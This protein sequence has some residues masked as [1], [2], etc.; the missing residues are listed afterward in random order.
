MAVNVG[1]LERIWFEPAGIRT[2]ATT[3]NHKTIGVRYLYTA[4]AFFVAAG[5]EALVLRTQLARPEG[6]L[7]GPKV[8]DELFSMHG[9]TMI[10][11]FITP[12]LSGFGN[13]FVPLQIGARDMAFPR[14]NAFSYWVYLSAGLFMYSSFLFGDAPNDGWFNYTPLSQKTHTPQLNSIVSYL[15]SL[16]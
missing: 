13:F 2:W 6:E 14:M 4:F 8:Y 12:M 10:F 16:R 3:V 15:E 5:L 11:L 1:R 7:V 9:V